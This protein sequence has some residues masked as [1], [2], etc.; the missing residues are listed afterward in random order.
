MN[1]E[2]LATRLRMLC[3]FFRFNVE[4]A[5]R[6][7]LLHGNIKLPIHAL[8]IRTCATMFPPSSATA[9]FIGWPISL[10]FLSAALIT[11]RASSNFTAVIASPPFSSRGERLL[12]EHSLL[13]STLREY[14]VLAWAFLCL[15]MRLA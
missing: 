2:E 11:R 14:E 4:C 13:L 6:V 3:Q 15:S 7:S 8:S 9:M 12:G 1:A 5:R 10:A